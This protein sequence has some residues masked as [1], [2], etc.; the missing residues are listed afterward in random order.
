MAESLKRKN[1]ISDNAMCF[2][3][4]YLQIGKLKIS[5]D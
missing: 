2:L 1:K 3:K 4:G 5:L